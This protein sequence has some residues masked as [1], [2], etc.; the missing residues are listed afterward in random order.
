MYGNLQDDVFEIEGALLLLQGVGRRSEVTEGETHSL[1]PTCE[2]SRVRS[3]T[4]KGSINLG[5]GGVT[6]PHQSSSA[7]NIITDGL[8]IQ[9]VSQGI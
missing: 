5:S 2:L 8:H 9:V 7:T 1:F 6:R 4:I 3:L